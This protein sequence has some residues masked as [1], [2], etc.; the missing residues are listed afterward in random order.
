[1]LNKT[2]IHCLE[3]FKALWT[4]CSLHW[5]CLLHLEL[6]G[7]PQ[8]GL[9]GEKSWNVFIKNLNFFST[10]ERKT[11]TC[12]MTWEWVNYQQ[13]F[14]FLL[15]FKVNYSFKSICMANHTWGPA[16]LLQSSVTHRSVFSSVAELLTVSA[17]QLLY[18]P[19]GKNKKSEQNKANNCKLSSV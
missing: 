1:L 6:F 10:E 3:S 7:Y 16:A 4:V 19:T 13:M 2:L 17:P 14:F 11:W 18:N 12:W 5:K 8:S 9:Y 15:F